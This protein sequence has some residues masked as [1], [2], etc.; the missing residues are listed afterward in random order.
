MDFNYVVTRQYLLRYY[1]NYAIT[2]L[3]NPNRKY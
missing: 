3:A 2:N 1:A